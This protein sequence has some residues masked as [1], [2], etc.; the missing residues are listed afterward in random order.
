MA[1]LLFLV[2]PA[3][4]AVLPTYLFCR[5]RI[6]RRKPVGFWAGFSG[7]LC[8]S[9]IMMLPFSGYGSSPYSLLMFFVFTAPA[10]FVSAALVTGYYHWRVPG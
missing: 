6:A 3:L 2:Y 9:L 10:S 4:I 8:G 5:Y 1:L 7:G